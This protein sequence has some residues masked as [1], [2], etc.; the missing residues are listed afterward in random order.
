MKHISFTRL[1]SLFVL[2]L[3]F[4]CIGTLTAA[5]TPVLAS[6]Y[7]GVYSNALNYTVSN[8]EVTITGCS[9]GMA[10]VT[11]PE[12]IDG[13]PVTAIADSAFYG[14]TYLTTL[15]IN[16]PI[17]HIGNDAFN[18]CGKLTSINIPDSVVSI[19]DRAFRSCSKLKSIT[20]PEG[21]VSIG[22]EA[23]C[24]CGALTTVS[25]PSTLEYIGNDILYMSNSVAYTNKNGLL[26]A[27]NSKNPYQILFKTWN[28]SGTVNIDTNTT[29]IADGAFDGRTNITDLHIPPSVRFIGL[30]A[31][32]NYSLSISRGV[33]ITDLESWCKIRFA[34]Q[35]SNPLYRGRSLYLN[36]ERIEE[37]SI[38][39]GI[40]A[41]S[42][43]T[44]YNNCYIKSISIPS[45]LTYIDPLAFMSC[46]AIESITVDEENPAYEGYGNCIIDKETR[47][48]ILGCKRSALESD[49]D[50]R[51]IGDY[52]FYGCYLESIILPESVTS[53]GSS[54]FYSCDNL[55]SIN[56]PDGVLKIGERAFYKCAILGPITLPSGL[57]EIENGTFY[58]CSN[59]GG[60]VIPHGVTRI[61]ISAFLGC[62]LDTSGITIP[63][64]VT[65]IEK[66]AF[67][68]CRIST[69]YYTGT[70]AQWNS[71][72]IAGS[73]DEIKSAPWEHLCTWGEWE[74]L[75]NATF[76]STGLC[77]KTCSVCMEMMTKV[78]PRKGDLDGD[79][80]LTNADITLILRELCGWNEQEPLEFS[81]INDD[82][83]VNNRDIITLIQKLAE[84][85]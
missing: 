9:A 29:I 55:T 60:V 16:A 72:S 31:F 34:N 69:V 50:I 8:G 13:Y 67:Y 59:L 45:S 22:D 54:A 12:E 63:Y 20:I 71:V 37:L 30:S 36:G 80:G 82:G 81:D 53:I 46:T 74:T 61:G 28:Y 73:N 32:S 78:T 70:I 57:T 4:L 26:Y 76:T 21:V 52:A 5:R 48:L 42:P 23:F 43:Y 51:A 68:H 10:W 38:P 58:E 19:G 2:I 14:H 65:S 18:S 1:L 3:S 79:G 77:G 24:A 27:G 35:Y 15:V 40:E 75:T 56:I 83:K 7:S 44:F 41:L 85:E 66:L 39:E 11:V 62:Y 84:A 25:F 64:T 6:E 33:H 17:K 49:D 47:T